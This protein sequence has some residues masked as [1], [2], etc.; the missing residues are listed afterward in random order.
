MKLYSII[1]TCYN[2]EKFISKSI[3]S[4]LNQI[5]INREMLEVIVVDDFSTDSSVEK[6]EEFIPLIKL[7]QNKKNFGVA[8][9]RNKGIK[10]SKG[11]YILM[12]DSDDYISNNYLEIVSFYLDNNYYWDAVACDYL[13]VDKKGKVIKRFNFRKKPI[14]CGI[15]FRRE[16]IFE[17]GLY[18][19]TL[20]LNEEKEL[21][22][23]FFKKKFKMGYVELP[24]YRYVMHED[25]ITKNIND[26]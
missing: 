2:R 8:A 19:K 5:N 3:R 18:N 9:S 10:I 12:L 24:L 13:K 25:N 15:L 21:R 4:A 22:K 11:K 7:I 16:K 23:K 17:I 1:I 20:R 14:A 6:I 26:T